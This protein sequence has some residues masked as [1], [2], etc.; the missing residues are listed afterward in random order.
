VPAVSIAPNLLPALTGQAAN[1]VVVLNSVTPRIGLTYALDD[2][3]RTLARASYSM[4]A[5]QL[6]SN[7]AT[8]LG[9]I[10]YSTIY[11]YGTDTNGDRQ[12]QASEL[13]GNL[14]TGAGGFNATGFN[15]SNPSS[16]VTPNVIG[17]YKVPL[18]HE[19]TVGLDRQLARDLAVSASYTNR[20]YT[21]FTWYHR[22]GVDGTDFTQTSTYSCTAAQ[23]NIVGPCSVPV[24]TINAGA[25]P[26]DG[27][28]I[29]E[30]RPG[31][32][33]TY[34]GLEIS[35]TKRMS[36]NWMARAA[37][38]ANV[39]REYMKSLASIQD[40]T[41]FAG[42]NAALSN[43][44]PNQ[45]G[46]LVSTQTA[47]SGKSGIFLVLPKYQF[48]ANGAYQ[49]KWGITTGL[50]YLFRQG[51]AQPFYNGAVGT[52]AKAGSTG[53]LLAGATGDYRLPSMHSL[54]M[55]IGKETKIGRAM[56]NFDIDAFNLLNL[57]TTLGKEYDLSLSTGGNIIEIMNP[58]I[59]RFGVRIGF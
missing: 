27:G 24:Y 41:P 57:A 55:R 58:R 50:N 45:D 3:R 53:L 23:R 19:F 7:Q 10:Q 25:A 11:F 47:G 34:Q 46:G 49:M 26:A 30:E 33:Q 21:N 43:L 29:F 38:S 4:F 17:D 28:K 6:P 54:D 22:K 15:L 2:S 31:Y 44:G 59:I 42:P 12:V 14:T 1:D 8:V 52:G 32:H 18:T 20:R 56:I 36:N 51:Y 37:W 40:P 13:T 48:I 35:A 9:T 39:H 5:S 16:L